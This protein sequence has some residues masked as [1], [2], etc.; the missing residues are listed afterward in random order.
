MWVK[1]VFSQSGLGGHAAMDF[2]G[3]GLDALGESFGDLGE[4]GVLAHQLEE[5]F[6][7]L[8]GEVLALFTGAGKIFAVLG[9]CIRMGLVAIRLAGLGEEDEWRGVGGLE[10]EGEIE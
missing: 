8:G 9:I 3:K 4:L 1:K 7:L 10:A 6:G 5:M 2:L